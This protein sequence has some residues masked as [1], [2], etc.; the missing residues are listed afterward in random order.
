MAKINFHR[1]NENKENKKHSKKRKI[2]YN[3]EV[4]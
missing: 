3:A 2:W 1:K 4:N